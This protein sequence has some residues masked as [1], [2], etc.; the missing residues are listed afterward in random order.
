LLLL[1]AAALAAPTQAAVE[2]SGAWVR[3]MP[4]TQSMTAAYLTLYNS[5]SEAVTVVGAHSPL[6]ASVEMHQSVERDGMARMVSLA[7]VPLAP[8]ARAE[9]VPG[10]RHLMLMGLERMPETGEQVSLCVEL[11][12]GEQVCTE[13]P[14]QRDAGGAAH[15]HHH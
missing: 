11:A 1:L 10:G 7:S 12:S 9:F 5:G 3:A 8:G 13:A 15:A 6:A 2:I 4:P 14:V